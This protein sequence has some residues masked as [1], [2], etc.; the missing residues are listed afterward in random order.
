MGKDTTVKV[1]VNDGAILQRGVTTYTAGEVLSLPAD[2]ADAYV[3][4][5]S[6]TVVS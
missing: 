3:E 1:R 2:E 6:A 5:G 4:S